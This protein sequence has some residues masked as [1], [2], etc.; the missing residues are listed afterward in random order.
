MKKTNKEKVIYKYYRKYQKVCAKLCHRMTK[1]GTNE[2]PDD[3]KRLNRYLEQMKEISKRAI[4]VDGEY[5][6]KH[7]PGLTLN[8]FDSICKKSPVCALGYDHWNAGDPQILKQLKKQ[9]PE[10]DYEQLDRSSPT[11]VHTIPK[12]G[13]LLFKVYPDLELIV[14]LSPNHDAVLDYIKELRQPEVIKL[15]L[16]YLGYEIYLK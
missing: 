1:K 14:S 11:D 15:V 5:T 13:T 6:L 12:S 4:M 2:I 16:Q 9:A 8:H 10:L 3:D 7:Y